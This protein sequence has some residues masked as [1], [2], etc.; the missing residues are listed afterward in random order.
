MT[1]MDL[2]QIETRIAQ[3]TQGHWVQRGGYIHLQGV[4]SP[5]VIDCLSQRVYDFNAN[6]A[7]I[8][9]AREDITALIAEVR[10]L[11]SALSAIQSISV[12]ALRP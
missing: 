1:D 6:A 5:C 8:C 12:E 2:N 11:R 4:E 9:S 10:K 3:T 7:F